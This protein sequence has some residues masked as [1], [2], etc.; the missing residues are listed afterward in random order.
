MRAFSLAL[1]IIALFAVLPV[2]GEE[3]PL[4]VFVGIPPFK[5]IVESIG[6]VHVEV[7]VLVPPGRDP[8]T[9]EPQPRQIVA[10]RAARLLFLSG[11]PFEVQLAEK[12]RGP[13]GL[14]EIIVL[15]E[16]DHDHDHDHD[17][18]EDPH[19]WLAPAMIRAH[20]AEIA[21][22]LGRADPEYAD[23]YTANLAV[24]LEQVTAV[25]ARVTAALA[26]FR[27]ERF[28]VFHPA[29]G[30]FG[31]AFGLEQVAIEAQGKSPSP[32]QLG[33]LITRA[34]AEGV[35][36][37]FVQAQFDA[38]AARAIAEA[39]AGAVVPL[40]PLAEDVLGNLVTIADAIS[41][42]LAGRRHE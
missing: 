31:A 10:L 41:T 33:D 22:A 36:I 18:G 17:R 40:D 20:A 39:I 23:Q 7:E 28:Y 34:R 8:H 15:G 16:G 6:G 38:R 1:G 3:E 30:R 29:F 19:T 27:G 26:P 4:A 21:A 25:E 14:P 35:R 5:S 24:Y 42:A 2:H 9:F 13:V 37:I 11:M 12:L 32:R